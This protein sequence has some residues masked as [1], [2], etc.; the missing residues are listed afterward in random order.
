MP[1]TA[2]V[3]SLAVLSLLGACSGDPG[4]GPVE[5]RWD[6]DVCVRCNMVLSDRHHSTQIR[7]TPGDKPSQ[8]YRFDDIG[9]AVIWLDGQTWK[10]DPSVEIWVS[11]HGSGRWIDARSAHYVGGHV[12]PME[13]GLGAQPAASAGTL[14]F[15]QAAAHIRA[16]ERRYNAHGAHL[17]AG[18]ETRRL[19]AIAPRESKP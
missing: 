13:Y 3:L 9:C 11:D 18:A 2:R 5:V 8:V 4:S 1:D 7:H 14:S 10:D 19:P 17:E 16:L 15:D 6:R 12:T